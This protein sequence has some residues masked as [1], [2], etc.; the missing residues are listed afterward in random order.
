MWRSE[1]AEA[2]AYP[3]GDHAACLALEDSSFWFRH[4]NRC[5]LE[6]VRKSAPAG[7]VLDIGGGNG[8]VARALI[9]AGFD[10]VVLEPG[11]E[12]A[13]NARITRGIPG[14]IC[15]SLEEAA[16]HSGAVPAVGMFDVLEHIKDDRAVVAQLYRI[17]QPQ[18]YLYLT[19]P[20]FQSL[21]SSHDVAAM[22]FR[23]YSQSS[24]AAVL[25]ERFDIVYMTAL[26]GRLV[27]AFFL[28]RSLPYALGLRR[29]SGRQIQAEHRAGGSALSALLARALS[30]EVDC[31]RR[32]RSLR[33]GSTL[34]VVARRR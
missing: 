1:R 31:I 10:A 24:M 4:R 12:G 26:F 32:D 2:V 6:A 3:E 33:W 22:H 13:R 18:G 25:R 17:L 20:A 27:P 21:W 23:R 11:S 7:F 16:I 30:H 9:D 29:S 34:L 14:V 28:A 19:V 8:F 5:I 15:A